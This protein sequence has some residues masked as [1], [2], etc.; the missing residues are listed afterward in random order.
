MQD[1]DFPEK[2]QEAAKNINIMLESIRSLFKEHRRFP[3]Q[4]E[5]QDRTRFATRTLKAYLQYVAKDWGLLE[6]GEGVRWDNPY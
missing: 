3:T 6:E 4:Q 5:L 2:R 1:F